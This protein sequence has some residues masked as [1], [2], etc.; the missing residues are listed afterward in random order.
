MS[1]S[2]QE[3]LQQLKDKNVVGVVA[4]CGYSSIK[5]IISIVVKKMGISPR[6]AYPFIKLGAKIYGK[7][8]IDEFNPIDAVKKSKVPIIFFRSSF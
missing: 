7:F 6:L 3:F 1:I 4:D 5:E 2:A 8:N